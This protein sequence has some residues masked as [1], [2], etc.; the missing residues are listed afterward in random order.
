MRKGHG[1]RKLQQIDTSLLE[2]VR[3]LNGHYRRFI[4]F[5]YKNPFSPTAAVLS[6]YVITTVVSLFTASSIHTTLLIKP[7]Q[8]P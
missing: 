1:L 6:K 3:D 4:T 2:N 8:D 7:A 5:R